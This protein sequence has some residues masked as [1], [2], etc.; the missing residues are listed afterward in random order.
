MRLKEFKVSC[1]TL[2]KGNIRLKWGVNG[3]SLSIVK[4]S[5]KPID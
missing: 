4:E 3:Q 1:P 5:M 2:T